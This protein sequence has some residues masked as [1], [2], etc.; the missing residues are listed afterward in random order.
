[1][2]LT[3]G[4][5]D[6]RDLPDDLR[7]AW[8]A[9]DG[10][11]RVEI[12]PREDARD[13]AANARFV[14]AVR[15]VSPDATGAPVTLLESGRTVVRAFSIAAISALGV[16]VLL[17]ALVL[18]RW[19]DIA[20]VVTPLGLSTLMTVAIAVAVGW[21]ITYANIITLPLM[22][23]IGVGFSI[24]FVIDWRAGEDRPLQSPTA[25]A[26]LFSALTTMAAFGSLALSSHPG[27]A[28]MGKLLAVALTATLIAVLAVL[29][30]LLARTRR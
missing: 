8:L 3:A 5:V 7:A 19:R 12:Y 27:T 15:A 6:L 2:A 23:G 17:L 13:P 16:V 28:D 26:V 29:P 24:Y 1:M 30:A 4:P 18:R 22:L 14:A 21:P 20:L 11:A 9:A 25:R 10:R